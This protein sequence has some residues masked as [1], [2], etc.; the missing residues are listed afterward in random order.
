MFCAQAEHTDDLGRYAPS[1]LAAE[2]Q[3]VGQLEPGLIL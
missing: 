2:F 3:D 1:V